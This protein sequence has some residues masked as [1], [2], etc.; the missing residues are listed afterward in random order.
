MWHFWRAIS[1]I[2][3]SAPRGG[4]KHYGVS[5]IMSPNLKSISIAELLSLH[6]G[7][8]GELRTRG[9]MR[10]ENIPTG[11]LAE[12]LFCR[13]YSWNQAANSEKAFDA[14][15]GQGNRYQIKGRRLNQHNPSRQLSAIRDLEGFDVLA[16]VLFDHEYRVSRAALIPNE[17][18]RNRS[19]HVAHDN[20]WNFILTDDVWNLENVEDVTKNLRTTW[21]QLCATVP[22]R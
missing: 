19:K 14:K 16:A 22:N 18:V 11:D 1:P 15:D 2:S 7:I 10:G 6:V 3:R 17:V 5:N 9:I 4:D 21:H 12:F 20:K 8:S 13:C